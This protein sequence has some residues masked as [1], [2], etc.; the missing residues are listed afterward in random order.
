MKHFKKLS[1]IAL[2]V[3]ITFGSLTPA[4]ACAVNTP[5]LI[6]NIGQADL[7]FVGKFEVTEVIRWESTYGGVP[8][9]YALLTFSVTETLKGESQPE[10][11]ILRW[12]NPLGSSTRLD[13][14]KT[15]IVAAYN[16]RDAIQAL[17]DAGVGGGLVGDASVFILREPACSS[18]P[19]FEN[20]A[21]NRAAIAA[22]LA[23]TG[24]E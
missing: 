3:A 10:W 13:P 1:T 14:E 20:S 4:T 6:V 18:A 5:P 17:N 21:E 23:Q 9:P 24:G 12:V 22:V 16:G 8:L 11:K 15:V 2:A 19:I 7:V